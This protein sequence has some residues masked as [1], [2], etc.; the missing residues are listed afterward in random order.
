VVDVFVGI[1]GKRVGVGG[2]RGKHGNEVNPYTCV[3]VG[4]VCYG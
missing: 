1:G 3:R 2:G 4:A